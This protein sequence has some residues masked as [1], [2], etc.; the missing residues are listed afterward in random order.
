MQVLRNTYKSRCIA[1]DDD[2]YNLPLDTIYFI[3]S[4]WNYRLNEYVFSHRQ[5]ISYILQKDFGGFF[6]YKIEIV[7]IEKVHNLLLQKAFTDLHPEWEDHIDFSLLNNKDIREQE[8]TYQTAMIQRLTSKSTVFEETFIA[9]M[10]PS[11]EEDSF[12]F[13]AIDTSLCTESLIPYI[14]EKYIQDLTAIN[15][16]VLGKQD[17]RDFTIHDEG[18]NIKNG[19]GISFCAAIPHWNT[20]QLCTSIEINKLDIDSNLRDLVLTTFAKI[21]SSLFQ[22]ILSTMYLSRYLLMAV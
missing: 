1:Y 16:S 7:S 6:P 13:Y 9:R 11:E 17:T 14:L 10:V 18:L 4:K 2:A 21:A 20:E 12:E 8:Q 19:Q 15:L 22:P 5:E 3:E